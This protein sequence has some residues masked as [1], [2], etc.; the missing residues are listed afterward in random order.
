MAVLLPEG[1]RC[2]R[3]MQPDNHSNLHLLRRRRPD[4]A[5]YCHS[6]L[7][8]GRCCRK[9]TPMKWTGFAIFCRYPAASIAAGFVLVW[10]VNARADQESVGATCA[11]NQNCGS[12][13]CLTSMAADESKCPRTQ[14]HFLCSVQGSGDLKAIPYKVC[15]QSDIIS[16]TCSNRPADNPISCTNLKV[17]YCGCLP[18][19]RVA[20]GCNFTSGTP[21]NCDCSGDPDQMLDSGVQW[22]CT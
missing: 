8:L 15:V 1:R 10:L 11:L 22:T 19:N 9:G 2:R 14:E 12:T 3:G 16:Q 7:R 5:V 21:N 13:N 17:W 18:D 20:T 4:R 6:Y